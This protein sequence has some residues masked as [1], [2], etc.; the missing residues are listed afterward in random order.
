M[1]RQDLRA[2]PRLFKLSTTDVNEDPASEIGKS[3]VNLSKITLKESEINL[4][5]K[6]LNY[7][8]TP[9]STDNEHIRESTEKFA[10][11]LKLSYHFR[12]SS[13]QVRH[14]FIPKSNWKP[15]DK[16]I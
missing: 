7:I 15:S 4:L 5:E 3:V 9:K 11:R 13:Y 10:R 14:K 6:G 16:V 1:C 12:R 8:P 2:H